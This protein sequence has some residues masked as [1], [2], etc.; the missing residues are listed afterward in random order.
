MAPAIAPLLGP[1]TMVLPAMNG[2]PWWF[3]AGRAGVGRRSRCTASTRAAPSPRR[4]PF[5]H[6][7]GCVVH[8]STF[9][10]EPGLV[11]HNMGQGLIVG[12]PAGGD[13]PRVQ[14]AGRAAARA[15]ASTSR[16]SANVRQ[17][18]LVQVVG[19]H[20]DE[21]GVGASPAPPSTACWTIRWCWRS[22]PRR[23]A[24][25]PQ[26]GARI[27]CAIEQSPEDR[28]AMTRK[29]GSF[30]TSM[31][32]DVEAGRTHRT[33]R[34]RRRGARDRRSAWAWPRR[35]SMRCSA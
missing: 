3:C 18:H 1:D 11:E 5:A 4:L 35:T 2:V 33:R 31:L 21:P 22:V 19:Q 7:L 34:H 9:T 6:V 14:R 13:S 8:A 26:I 30:K 23:C 12:E 28:H 27:G 20:D 29:L 32:Q 10:P 17:R 15:P 25:P 24:R 16:M